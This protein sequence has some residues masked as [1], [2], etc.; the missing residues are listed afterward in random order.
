MQER[1]DATRISCAERRLG[2]I[3]PATRAEMLRDVFLTTGARIEGGVWANRLTIETP[4]VE[5]RDAVYARGGITIRAQTPQGLTS[6]GLD[7]ESTV[8]T[9]DSIV[10]AD[11]AGRVRIR[12]NVYAG[13][14]N[15]R[16]CIIYGNVYATRASLRDCVVVGG[17]FVR[18]ALD[19]ENCVLGTF[20]CDSAHLGVNT[21]LIVPNGIASTSLTIAADVSCLMFGALGSNGNTAASELKL[22]QGDVYRVDQRGD[23]T[24]IGGTL[25]LTASYRLLDLR[26]LLDTLVENQRLCTRLALDVHLPPAE[27]AA[28]QALVEVEEKFFSVLTQRSGTPSRRAAQSIAELRDEARESELARAFRSFEVAERSG[29]QD[30]P[31]RASGETNPEESLPDEIARLFVPVSASP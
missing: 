3:Q 12:S 21:H 29:D 26:P 5:V 31:A 14:A 6:H 20:A 19:A 30:A 22:T 15:L 4:G 10:V 13:T 16:N 8:V 7:I 23:R 11:E 25:L 27:K 24:D 2:S 17:V 28:S 9:P 1:V 18:E